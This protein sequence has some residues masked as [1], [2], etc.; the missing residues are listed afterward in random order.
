MAEAP[1]ID[2]GPFKGINNVED[3]VSPVYARDA[4]TGT[5]YLR[6]AQNVDLSRDGWLRR[7]SGYTRLLTM[8]DGHSLAAVNGLLLGADGGTLM[9]LFPG[10]D[11]AGTRAETIRSGLAPTT[12]SY[13]QV[14]AEV[15]W[16]NGQDRGRITAGGVAACWGMEPPEKPVLSTVA[17]TLPAGLYLVALTCENDEGLESGAHEPA[18]I[19]LTVPGAIRVSVTGIDPAATSVNIYLTDT[20]GRDLFWAENVTTGTASYILSARAQSTAPIQGLVGIYPPP[21]GAQ[22]VIGYRG[23]AVVAFG[24][25]LAWSQPLAYHHFKRSTDIQ[26]FAEPIVM[27]DALDDGFYVAEGNRTWWVA[28]DDPDAWTPRQVDNIPVARGRALKLPGRKIPRLE[29]T[30]MVLVWASATGPVAGLPGGVIVH[31][32]EDAVAMHGHANASLAFREERGIAQIMMQL[33]DRNAVNE[34]GFSDR[35]EA[36]VIKANPA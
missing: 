4:D 27:L 16:C 9:R 25:V 17:G 31:L 1:L 32:T 2:V 14:G 26:L 33:R 5:A 23:R 7:R 8:T 24:N 22:F 34:F 30:A 36:T 19:E 15:L 18:V 3:E 28:G 35:M 20:N 13:A 10:T 11:A 12:I 21:V 6:E 29:T